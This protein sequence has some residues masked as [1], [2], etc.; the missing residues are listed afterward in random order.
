[1]NQA[2]S[3]EPEPKQIKNDDNE[4]NYIMNYAALLCPVVFII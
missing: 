3:P 1:M 2:S 4:T